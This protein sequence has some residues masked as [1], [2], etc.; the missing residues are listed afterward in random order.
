MP[1]GDVVIVL[2]TVLRIRRT[3]DGV[4]IDR[5][6]WDVEAHKALA[7]EHRRRAEWRKSELEAACF[8]A[9]CHPLTAARF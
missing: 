7:I 5:I 4:E 1:Y 3:L 9:E 2:S 8:R 6:I